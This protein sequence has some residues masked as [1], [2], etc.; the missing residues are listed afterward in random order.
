MSPQLKSGPATF[1]NNCRRTRAWL[2]ICLA[3]LP[4]PALAGHY[5]YA[6]AGAYV[7]EDPHACTPLLS[8]WPSYLSAGSYF[9]YDPRFPANTQAGVSNGGSFE[10]FDLYAESSGDLSSGTLRS[11]ARVS[12]ASL[13]Q[14]RYATA[15]SSV[16]MGDS[17]SFA[18][19]QGSPFAWGSSSEVTLKL[20]LDG[21]VTNTTADPSTW[22]AQYIVQ[23][24]VFR[25]GAIQSHQLETRAPVAQARWGLVSGGN[26]SYYDASAYGALPI[27]AAV[28]GS[29]EAGGLDL[30]ISFQPGGDFDWDLVLYTGAQLTDLPGVVEADFSHTLN[31]SFVVPTGAITTSSSGLF[32][33]TSAVPEPQSWMLML[34]GI[35]LLGWLRKQSQCSRKEMA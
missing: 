28:T 3:T 5:V 20:H 1:L 30:Q 26:V 6:E 4:A 35:G 33:V 25:H 34:G 15:S 19:A 29:L 10:S 12:N 17:F 32:P 23:F 21:S 27:T 9:T 2:W 31:G 24:A 11:T 16:W 14:G 13:A 18:N 7:C 22:L 8:N